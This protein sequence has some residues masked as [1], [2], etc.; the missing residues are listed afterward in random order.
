MKDE[1]EEE[2]SKAL[3]LGEVPT[4]RVQLNALPLSP[5]FFFV[6]SDHA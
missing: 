5:P 4:I 1:E 2:E 6:V 3:P